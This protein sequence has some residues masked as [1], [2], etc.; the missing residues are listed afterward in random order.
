MESRFNPFS[1][2]ALLSL[3]FAPAASFFLL[4]SRYFPFPVLAPYLYPPFILTLSFSSYRPEN[5]ERERK[6]TSNTTQKI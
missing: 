3:S 5:T 4:L 2:D 6:Q 1:N